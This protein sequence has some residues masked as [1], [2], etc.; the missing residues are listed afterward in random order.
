MSRIM[1]KLKKL[2]K[3]VTTSP[4]IPRLSSLPPNEVTTQ[5]GRRNNIGIA[6]TLAAVMIVGIAAYIAGIKSGKG[7]ERQGEKPDEIAGITSK[8]QPQSKSGSVKTVSTEV[9][10]DIATL[11]FDE[12]DSIPA[13]P[14]ATNEKNG[15]A[16][17]EKMID[18]EQIPAEINEPAG[19]SGKG[20]NRKAVALTAAII[21]AT[22][23]PITSEED[24]QNKQVVQKLNVLGIVRDDKGVTAIISGKEVREGDKIRQFTVD[25]ITKDYVVL[26]YKRTYYRKLVR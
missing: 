19:Y 7:G 21:K 24:E 18:I 14:S 10:D 11:V 22:D 1:S 6:L 12:K 8:E 9:K 3:T 26:S 17:P 15:S 20:D 13:M 25:E 2:E 16:E 23:N 5:K 4:D